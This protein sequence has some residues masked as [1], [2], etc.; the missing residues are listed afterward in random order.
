M[1]WLSGLIAL[2]GF[3]TLAVAADLKLALTGEN[4]TVEF[5]GTKKE[6]KHDGGFK[7]LTGT[8]VATST[9]PTTLAFD[10]VID[11][12]SLWSDNAMLTAHLKGADFFDV[13]TN[14]TAKFKSTKVEKTDAGYTVHGEL[15]LNGKTKAVHFP[16][17]V[18]LS[19]KALKLGS[20]F[21]IKK[22]DFGM[23]YGAGKID[24][25]VA[26]RV[27]IETK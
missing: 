25:D 4:T 21:T 14:P 11:T 27:K 2:G 12:E 26:L 19:D 10:V 15:T 9:D 22:S 20:T 8:A 24:D 5:T 6:G 7:K 16:A 1:R 18:T 17:Q 3:V 13:K 23:N